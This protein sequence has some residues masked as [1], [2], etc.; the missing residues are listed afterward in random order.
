[1][2]LA[3]DLLETA[4]KLAAANERRP[5]QA[6]LRRATSTAYYAVFHALAQECADRFVGTGGQR[7]DAAWNQVYR[8]LEHRFAAQQARK[9]GQFGFPAGLCDFGDAFASLQEERH[10]ADYDPSASYTKADVEQ[11]LGSTQKALNDLENSPKADRPAFAALVLFKHR[12]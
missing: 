4:T 5:K 6:D 2:A 1:M 12:A 8:A 7:S 10:R 3:R 9:A 11:L